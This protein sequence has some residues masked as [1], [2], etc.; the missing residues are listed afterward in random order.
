MIPRAIARLF[1]YAENAASR[2]WKYT[3][4]ASLLE[5]YNEEIRDLLGNN[6]SSPSAAASSGKGATKDSSSSSSS[7]SALRISQDRLGRVSVPGLSILS[8]SSCAQMISLLAKGSLGRT[9]ASTACNARSSR[10]HT[11]F[12]IH[13]EGSNAKNGTEGNSKGDTKVISTLNLVDLAGSERLDASKAGSNPTLLKETQAINS[14]LSALV[15]CMSAIASKSSH[16]GF[17]DSALTHLLKDSLA[18]AARSSAG[19]GVAAPPSRTLF[20]INIAPETSS[21]Q[22]TICTLRFADKLKA[23]EMNATAAA[24]GGA[25]QANRRESIASA[26]SSS[27]AAAAAAADAAEDSGAVTTRRSR[28]KQ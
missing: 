2:G 19:S 5:I 21:F 4:K 9:I 8:V 3:F 1:S 10:S 28:R 18:G 11:V 27:S 25:A 24:A 14:S 26:A 23:V 6:H 7:S 12:T 22:E 16:V 15:T 13:I 17:R 20:F